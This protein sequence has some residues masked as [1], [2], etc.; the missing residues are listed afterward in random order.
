MQWKLIN[1]SMDGIV[2]RYV[3]AQSIPLCNSDVRV[4][5]NGCIKCFRNL[6]LKKENCAYTLNAKCKDIYIYVHVLK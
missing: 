1:V 3:V 2:K 4:C 6:R 5:A